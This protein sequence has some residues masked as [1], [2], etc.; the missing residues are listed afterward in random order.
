MCSATIGLSPLPKGELITTLAPTPATA[1]IAGTSGLVGGHLLRL[2]LQNGRYARVIAMGRREL[3]G[4]RHPKLEQRIVDFDALERL[5]PAELPPVNDVF[6]CLGT[7][8]RKAGSRQ[9]F[10]RVDHDYV[11]ALGRLGLAAGATQFLLVSAVSAD[12]SSRVFYSRVKGET[13]SALRA[14]RYTGTQIF[15]PSLLLGQRREFRLGERLAV[16]AAPLLAP[17]C[18]GP[19]RRYRPVAARTVAQAM[20][21]IAEAAPRG[22]NV[23]EYDGIAAAV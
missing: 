16:L 14:L 15:R 12:P 20:V 3:P 19:W 10:R 8:I 13:E 9:A 7:T 5:A 18:I 1:L 4:L 6:C 21:R 2:L 22:P 17:L 11:V 23:F